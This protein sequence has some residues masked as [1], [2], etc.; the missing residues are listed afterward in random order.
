MSDVSLFGEP[1]GSA[2]A[3]TASAPASRK[4]RNPCHGLFGAKLE[5]AKVSPR[6]STYLRPLASLI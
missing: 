5:T 4:P 3:T 2:P 1:S 6:L